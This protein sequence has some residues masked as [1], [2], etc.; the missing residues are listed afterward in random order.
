FTDTFTKNIFELNGEGFDT[1][2]NSFLQATFEFGGN[3]NHLKVNFL[4]DPAMKLSR[5]RK[6]LAIDNVE[7]PLP[8]LIRALDFVKITGHINNPNGTL[9]TNFNGKVVI[10]IY[11][12]RLNKTTLNNDGS[13]TPILPYSE[14]GSP[15]VK[16]SG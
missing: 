15:I 16:A 8:G 11:D 3:P 13:L 14:E 1:L 5:P 4:G 12:K 9:N 6:L 10:N 7:T 2:G